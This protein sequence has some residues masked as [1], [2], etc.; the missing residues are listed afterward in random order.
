M[1][2]TALPIPVILMKAL[3]DTNI[4]IDFLGGRFPKFMYDA[5]IER[6]VIRLSPVV[7]HELIRCNRSPKSKQGFEV[8]A[9][10]LLFLPPPTTKMWI[11]AGEIAGKIIGNH[12]ER[13]L[14]RI[15]NDLLIALTA[16]ENGAVLITRDKLFSTIQKHITFRMILVG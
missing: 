8:P 14:E 16:R 9:K 4:Y 11:T 13:S 10:R 7:Y 2:C 15:Q 5:Y 1:P 6:F 3:F 12:D